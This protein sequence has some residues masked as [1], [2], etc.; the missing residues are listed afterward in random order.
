MKEIDNVLEYNYKKGVN[1]FYMNLLCTEYVNCCIK[2]LTHLYGEKP[3]EINITAMCSHLNQCCTI[4]EYKESC[5]KFIVEVTNFING[6]KKEK[7]YI[8]DYLKEYVGN[9]YSEDIYLDLLSKKMNITKAYISAYFK[10]KTG[11]NLSD[12]INNFRVQKAMELMS[13]TSINIKNIGKQ[14]GLLNT[15]TFIRIFK[16][17]TG[18]TPNE[19][20]KKMRIS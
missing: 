16:K 8:V 3:E 4:Q 10:N 13:N 17:C 9:H 6:N 12:Y 5:E 14:V 11:A 1:C 7:D 2:V 15:N 20:R 19:Y 18:K